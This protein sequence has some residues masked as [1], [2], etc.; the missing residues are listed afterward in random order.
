MKKMSDDV[1]KH[2]AY[3]ALVHRTAAASTGKEE[4]RAIDALMRLAKR[5]PKSLWLY[6]ASG[7]LNVMRVGERGEH[8]VLPCGGVDPAYSLARVAIPNDGGDW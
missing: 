6:S 8:V 3:E 4:K 7:A 5:W 1:M 2:L